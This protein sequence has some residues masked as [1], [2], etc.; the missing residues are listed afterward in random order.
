M[1]C[2]ELVISVLSKSPNYNLSVN[3]LFYLGDSLSD[4]NSPMAQ[5]MQFSTFDADHD[6][7]S[8]NC[9]IAY[10]GAWWYN[11]CHASNL[12]GAYLGGLTRRT[13]TGSSGVPG[14]F[15]TIL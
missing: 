11:S 4:P 10:H 8:D 12:N 1:V 3:K 15:I 9:A 14:C 5:G 13:L 6:L 2:E 7:S